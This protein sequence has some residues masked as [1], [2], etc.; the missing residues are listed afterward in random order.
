MKVVKGFKMR[1]ICGEKVIVA[2]GRA[3]I[4]FNKVIS[5]NATAAYLWEAV[6]A[7]EEFSVEDMRD[8]LLEKYDVEEALA[9]SDSE[10]L[11]KAWLEIGIVAE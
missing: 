8:L 5:L 6:S 2:E 10:K 3:T 4:D 1:E 9:F 11:A 7:R